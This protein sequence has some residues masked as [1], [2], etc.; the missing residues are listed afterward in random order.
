MCENLPTDWRRTV[1]LHWQLRYQ[2]FLHRS[3]QN[4]ALVVKN[5]PTNAGDI[6]DAGSIP[7]SGRSSGEGNGN[8]LQI[9]A[10]KIPWTGEPGGLQSLGL[11]RVKH[12]SD[13]LALVQGPE[14]KDHSLQ[15]EAETCLA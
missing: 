13:S 3:G 7:A 12:H 5:A 15:E 2:S 14:Q 8:P 6:R 9:L 1:A 11:Q 4:K 10:W